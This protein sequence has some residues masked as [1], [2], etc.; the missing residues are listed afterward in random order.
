MLGCWCLG[1]SKAVTGR[2]RSGWSGGLMAIIGRAGVGS[3]TRCYWWYRM[4]ECQ[5]LLLVVQDGGV[6]KVVI[7][8][9]GW[10]IVKGCYGGIGW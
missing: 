2:Y 10:W 4:V 1:V 8:G 7:G 9:T 3:V 5:R 6:L